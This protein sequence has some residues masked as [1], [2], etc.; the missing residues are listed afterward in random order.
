[1]VADFTISSGNTNTKI[2]ITDSS[3]ANY[4]GESITGRSVLIL[5]STGNTTTVAFPIVTGVGDSL[6]YDLVTIRAV[7]ISLVLT[8]A[9]VIGGSVYI[10]QYTYSSLNAFDK[11]IKSLEDRIIYEV[12]PRSV[13]SSPQALIR[14]FEW[15]TAIYDS[16]NDFALTGD[17]GSTQECIDCLV[18]LSRNK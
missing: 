18:E 8:P 9:T 12:D 3:T 2:I 17:I 1:M 15:A 5:D 7:K 6:Q 16:G 13:L 4:G 10:K 14:E 11:Y